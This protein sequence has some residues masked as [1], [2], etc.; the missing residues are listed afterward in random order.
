[1][2]RQTCNGVVQGIM[3][4]VANDCLV[5]LQR[6]C[7]ALKRMPGPVNAEAGRRCLRRMLAASGL[8]ALIAGLAACGGPR[9]TT[10]G[11]LFSGV[12]LAFLQD[13]QTTCEDV[14]SVLGTPTARRQFTGGAFGNAAWFYVSQRVSYYAFFEPEVIE[15]RVLVVQYDADIESGPSVC[16]ANPQVA[17]VQTLTENDFRNMEFD[18]DATVVVGNT[19]TLLQELF[20]DIGRF[21]TPAVR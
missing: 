15:Q 12:D 4:R 5:M 1:M 3:E 9:V 20:G 11:F 7:S 2:P 14:Y 8:V 16:G 10:S 17:D 18:P 21:S 19:R 13:E 6:A